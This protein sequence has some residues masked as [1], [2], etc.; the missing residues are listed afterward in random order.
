[1]MLRDSTRNGRAAKQFVPSF[2]SSVYL[3]PSFPP[4]CF[5][6]PV[7]HQSYCHS[8]HF[9]SFF[10]FFMLKLFTRSCSSIPLALHFLSSFLPHYFCSPFICASYYHSSLHILV[11]INY[12]LAFP[13]IV[14]MVQ[15]GFPKH[16]SD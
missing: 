2:H 7:T 6:I 4:R 14:G 12:T 15:W 9:C 13:Q 8:L 5:H 3:L 1:M 16:E 10:F 11:M